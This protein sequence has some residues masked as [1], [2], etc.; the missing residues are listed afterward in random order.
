MDSERARAS[1]GEFNYFG[2]FHLWNQGGDLA[3]AAVL[4]FRP[5]FFCA[6]LCLAGY[7][8]AQTQDP[9]ST[10]SQAADEDDVFVAGE[11][12]TLEVPLDS[13]SFLSGG[14]PIDS[15]GFVE[16]PVFGKFQVAGRYRSEVEGYLGQ[17]FANYL[18]DTHIKAMPA[19][20]I[21]LLGHFVRQ[22]MYYLNPR[23][24]VWDA[25]YLSGGLAG[26]R[27]LDR[28]EILR[29]TQVTA[30]SFL[31]EYSKGATFTKAGIRSGDIIVVPVPREN[32]GFWY[33]F[34]ETI[35][36]TAQI[37]A[38]LTSAMSAYII[39]LNL[40]DNNNP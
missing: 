30:I 25:V 11:A 5:F 7:V 34:R 17:K 22:G 4:F 13:A 40:N 29:G 26:E 18:K 1:T 3:R 24:T 35:T 31:D 28:I 23:A 16:L 20:R 33:W 6:L 27:T 38:V 39:Y 9:A 32:I 10:L 37:A 14:Y 21:T 15:A 2:V 12:L 19:I 36:L 8:P